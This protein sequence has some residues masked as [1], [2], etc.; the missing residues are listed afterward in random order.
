MLPRGGEMEFATAVW[1]AWAAVQPAPAPET[2]TWEAIALSGTERRSIAKGATTYE[3][4]RDVVVRA[5]QDGKSWSKSILL[6]DAFALGASV[7]RE[8]RLEGFGLMVDQR[9]DANGFSWE[10]FDL[11]KG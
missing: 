10:W 8:R 11:E 2:V 9:N 4:S 6:N 3:P 1:L 5:G 7:H